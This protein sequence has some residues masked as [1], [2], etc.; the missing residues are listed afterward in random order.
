VRQTFVSKCYLPPIRQLS[1]WK[2][3]LF[4]LKLGPVRSGSA[5][6][7]ER[8]ISIA[9]GIP[10]PNSGQRFVQIFR[11][12]STSNYSRFE[13]RFLRRERILAVSPIRPHVRTRGKT[14]RAVRPGEASSSPKVPEWS[15]LIELTIAA[16]E[17][18]GIRLTRR[19]PN[20]V[21]WVLGPKKMLREGK[22]DISRNVAGPFV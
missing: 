7:T 10:T 16:A 15:W 9:T 18:K 14:I 11:L 6:E 17:A 4:I 8:S 22:H 13:N 2:K 12:R 20:R 5:T 21:L 3:W 1:S 19:N